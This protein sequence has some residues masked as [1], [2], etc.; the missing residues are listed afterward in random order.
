LFNAASLVNLNAAGITQ[1]TSVS[2]TNAV[3]LTLMN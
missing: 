2:A 1:V 3:P